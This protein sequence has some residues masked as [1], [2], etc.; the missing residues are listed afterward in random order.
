MVLYKLDQKNGSQMGH[1]SEI[2]RQKNVAKS[3]AWAH[4]LYEVR[5]LYKN[6]SFISGNMILIVL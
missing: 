1:K 4:F 3:R 5:S 2:L 6:T